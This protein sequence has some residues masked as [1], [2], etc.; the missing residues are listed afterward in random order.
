MKDKV[1]KFESYKNISFDGF[2]CPKIKKFMETVDS[3]L[4]AGVYDFEEE[5]YINVIEPSTKIAKPTLYEV[6]K[7]YYDIHCLLKGEEKIY[8]ANVDGME[9]NKEYDK[10]IEAALYNSNKDDEFINYFE[11][12]AVAILNPVGHTCLFAVNNEMNIKK[13]IIKVKAR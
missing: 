11:G 13:A 4:K 2:N 7:E 6:H 3:S 1:I 9:V 10:E 5:G 8:L 12:E